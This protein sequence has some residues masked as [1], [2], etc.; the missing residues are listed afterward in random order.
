MRFNALLRLIAGV[1]HR[2]LT[3]TLRRL[4]HDGLRALSEW[5]PKHQPAIQAARDSNNRRRLKQPSARRTPRNA[6]RYG[7]GVRSIVKSPASVSY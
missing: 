1:S 4:E 5:A 6:R 2:M 3:L 7:P